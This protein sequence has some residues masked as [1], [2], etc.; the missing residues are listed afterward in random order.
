MSLEDEGMSAGY[1][2]EEERESN[3]LELEGS[4]GEQTWS[5]SLCDPDHQ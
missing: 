3:T 4:A 1:V 5:C 2:K